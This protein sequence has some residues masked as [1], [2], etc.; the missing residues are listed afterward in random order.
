MAPRKSGSASDS[1]SVVRDDGEDHEHS[2][3]PT[4]PYAV[5]REEIEDKKECSICRCFV[6]LTVAIVVIAA[7][8][9]GV[10][11]YFAKPKGTPKFLASEPPGLNATNKW[12]RS[13]RTGLDLTV[14]NA[15][16]DKYTS[17]FEEMI[18]KW[19]NGS[20]DALILS[21]TRVTPEVDCNPSVG[22]LKICSGNYGNTDWRGINF[23]F[24]S[25]D[26]IIYSTS[27]VNNYHLD[28]ENNYQR[29]YTV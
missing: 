5:T 18:T 28:H 26:Y 12:E 10:L 23:N 14:E 7:I 20:P 11:F 6:R 17:A 13:T 15:M 29:R 19:D 1:S 2:K 27:K 25:N 16:E 4:I 8:T 22:R 24:V 9:V 3:A 21:P